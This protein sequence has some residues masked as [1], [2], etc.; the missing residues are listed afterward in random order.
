MRRLHILTAMTALAVLGL[1]TGLTID[2]AYDMMGIPNW[3]PKERVARFREYVEIVDLLLVWPGDLDNN[4][5][6]NFQDPLSVGMKFGLTGPTRPDSSLQ[7]IGQPAPP[8]DD[9]DATFV[10][11]RSD[12]IINQN[13]MLAIGLNWNKTHT[14]NA[15][16]HATYRDPYRKM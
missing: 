2:P 11:S 3:G 16:K 6:V 4:R 1:G 10:D 5:I 14:R 9:I 13:D 8:S 7:W 12:G 15:A